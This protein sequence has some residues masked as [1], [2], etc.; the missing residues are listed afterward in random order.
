MNIYGGGHALY[1]F[2]TKPMIL[3]FRFDMSPRKTVS[4]AKEE[5]RNVT[6]TNDTVRSC[7]VKKGETIKNLNM[8]LLIYIKAM[9]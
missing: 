9:F 3:K 8:S 5:K 1:G 6:N 7:L 2:M 4:I